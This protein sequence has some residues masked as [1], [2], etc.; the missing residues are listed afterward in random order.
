MRRSLLTLAGA[1]GLCAG[2]A[3]AGCDRAHDPGDTLG[4]L[5]RDRLELVAESNERV[6]EL[7]VTEGEHV[8]AG[9]LLA[10]QEAGTMEP[11]LA[12]GRASLAE[13][14]QRL[15]ELVHGPRARELDEAGATLKGAESSLD[16]ELREFERVRELV[17]RKL[18]PDSELDQARARRDVALA[19]RDEARARLRLLKEGT[20]AEQLAQ[21]RA[22]VERE[23][24]ALA[25]LEVTAERYAVR[26]PRA[27][28][29]EALPYEVGE[30]P[31]VG[32][33]LAI[34]LADG[35][36]YA[37]VHIPEPLRTAYAPG[38]AVVV[39]V[40]GIAEAIPGKVRYVSAQA[41]FTPYFA[42]T[43]QDRSRLAYL[44][45]ITLEGAQATM[46]PAGVPVQVRL[47]D[48]R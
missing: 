21:A 40:D 5:E 39:H 3:S 42:L 32:A 17:S 13:A 25:E 45:E 14:E 41:S 27:G 20:R 29:V 37:R 1:A 4:T 36:P 7:P 11:R 28:L 6:V 35:A 8:A 23:R 38:S 12:Q 19:S 47:A 15:D 16:T 34:L 48:G 10:R 9:A 2:L 18:L 33:P 24:A 26:A 30:R 22:A 44:A 31:P 46:L 43:Q